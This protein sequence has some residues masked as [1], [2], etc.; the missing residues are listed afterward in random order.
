MLSPPLQFILSLSLVAV[1]SGAFT[2]RPAIVRIVELPMTSN[3][4]PIA[5]QDAVTNMN[6]ERPIMSN[7][8]RTTYTEHT[9]YELGDEDSRKSVSS[10]PSFEEYMN[11]R[12]PD[13]Q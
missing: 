9:E 8:V 7:I 11:Q 4:E 10:A 12:S 5:S 13:D 1:A 6:S 2:P 3:Q